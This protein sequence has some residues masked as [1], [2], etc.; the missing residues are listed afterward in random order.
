MID[1]KGLLIVAYGEEFIRYVLNISDSEDLDE[2]PVNKPEEVINLLVQFALQSAQT[3]YVDVNLMASAQLAT[4]LPEHEMSLVVYYRKLCGGVIDEKPS[5]DDDPVFSAL[6]LIARDIWPLYLISPPRGRRGIGFFAANSSVIF[7]H[8]ELNGLSQAFM[9]DSSLS[10]LFP[11]GASDRVAPEPMMESAEWVMTSGHSGTRQLLGVLTQLLYDARLRVM[12][13][14]KRLTLDDLSRALK[15]SLDVLR[16]LADGQTVEVP[17]VIGFSGIKLLEGQSIE[18]TDGTLRSVRPDEMDHLLSGSGNAGAVYETTYPLRLL[19]A[20]RGDLSASD[21]H[22]PFQ[23]Y[24]AR[25]DEAIRSFEYSLEKVRLSLLLCS[26][27]S[28]LIAPKEES[29]LL[30]DPTTLGGIAQWSVSEHIPSN[31]EIADG[32]SDEVVE[33]YDLIRKKHSESLNIAMKRLLSAASSRRDSNDALI[34]AL[35]AWENMFGTRSETTFRVTASLAKILEGE[36]DARRDLQRELNKLYAVRSSMVHGAK[37]PGPEAA[38][39]NRDRVIRVAIDGLRCLY[40]ERP[41][42]LAMPSE[43]RSKA[44]LLEG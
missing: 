1:V 23:K 38:A 44:V 29:R 14:G 18:F 15:V 26:D 35:I 22:K 13:E 11:D 43:E 40:R 19:H 8:P 28:N 20:S 27:G 42:L 33:M 9:D 2:F 21:W 17:A 32:K 30:F 4:Y 16:R 34:D 24:R 41:D 12:L 25:I 31:T 7:R 6:N 39:A 37:E 3:G 10:K 5:A 36:A